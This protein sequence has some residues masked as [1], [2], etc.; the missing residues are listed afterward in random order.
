MFTITVSVVNDSPVISVT[1]QTSIAENSAQAVAAN[2][3]AT[4][5]DDSTIT[6]ALTGNGAD[7]ALFE[8][9]DGNLRIKA[10]ADYEAQS[11]Y[12]VQVSATDAS[13]AVT[14]KNI[15]IIV[16]DEAES[17][18][19][20]IVDGYVAGA[21]V[22][23]DL[24]NDNVLDSGEPYTV[25]SATGAFTLDGVVSSATAPLKMITGFDI[26]TNQ[27]IVTS[28]GVPTTETGDVVASPLGTIA[29]LTQAN[30][31][32]VNISTIIDRVATY[33]GVSDAS[34]SNIDLINDDP[35]AGMK[36]ASSSVVSASQDAFQANQ[37]IMALAH[38]AETFG[39]YVSGII[40]AA[41]QTNL[42][43]SGISD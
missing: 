10:S 5:E 28:L 21:T 29:T 22:F 43:N 40:D 12:R 1:S 17:V 24:D 2:L 39:E 27:A 15:E 30:D 20:T 7:D 9:V 16:T 34:Q 11:L 33:F 8:I 37:Y 26:G 19:G 3:S 36:N 14:L 32:S 13:G 23:Q 31:T 4:D 6:L 18:A 25:T 42:L 35:I 41:I 38:S